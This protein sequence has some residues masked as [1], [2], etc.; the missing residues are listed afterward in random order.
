VIGRYGSK[1]RSAEGK[2]KFRQVWFPRRDL[3][4]AAKLLHAGREAI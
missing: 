4:R 3:G 1:P 2:I